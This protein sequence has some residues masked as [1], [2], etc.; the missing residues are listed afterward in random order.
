LIY[1]VRNDFTGFAIAAFIVWKLIVAS[2][3]I[4]AKLHLL[5]EDFQDAKG[6]AFFQIFV[7]LASQ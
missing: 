1:S 5:V 4:I 6:F 2:T 7:R 3:I